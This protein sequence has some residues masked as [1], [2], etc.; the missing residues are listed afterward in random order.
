MAQQ[1]RFTGSTHQSDRVIGNLVI[2]RDFA[3]F[4]LCRDHG[5]REFSFYELASTSSVLS[6]NASAYLPGIELGPRGLAGT[7]GLTALAMLTSTVYM[8]KY[9]R[10]VM[11]APEQGRRAAGKP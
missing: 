1:G 9:Y 8:L 3:A 2:D 6:F 5:T 10:R 11:D 7:L 4:V